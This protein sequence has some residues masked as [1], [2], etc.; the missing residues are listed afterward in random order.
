VRLRVEFTGAFG[1]SGTGVAFQALADARIRISAA[2]RIMDASSPAA[3]S[4]SGRKT[5][6]AEERPAP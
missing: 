1:A 5:S 6:K 2:S 4:R 3:S